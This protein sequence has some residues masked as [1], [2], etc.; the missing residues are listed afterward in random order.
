MSAAQPE[1]R[2]TPTARSSAPTPPED[3]RLAQHMAVFRRGTVDLIDEPSLRLRVAESLAEGRPLR[4]KFGMDPT[5]PDLH[6]GHAVHLL[7]LRDLQQL[8]HQIVLIVG[9]ATAMVGD[10]SGRN[11]L[12]PQLSRADVEEHLSTYLEQAGRVLELDRT[13]VRR[14]SEWFDAMR[15]EDVLRLAAK[16]TVAQMIERDTF[17]ARIQQAEPIG[18]HELLYPLMQGWDSVVVRSDVELGGTDQL[19]NLLVGRALQEREDQRP[20][21][22][23]TLPLLLGLDGRKMS[24]SYANYV[25][26]TDEPAD[27]FGKVMSIEDGAMGAWFRLLTRMPE[28]E[29]AQTLAGHPRDA[30]ARLAGELT[31]FFHGAEPAR[32]AGLAFDRLFRDGQVPEDVPELAWPAEGALPLAS[33]LHAVGLAASTSEARRVIQQGGVRLDGALELDPL[34]QIPPPGAG[35][36]VQV[37][38]RRFLRLRS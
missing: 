26:F 18:L 15:F 30:K 22:V 13:E 25:G 38:K 24:K 6:V 35:L 3:A 23:V 2:S 33:L 37:G 28:A 34:R 1:P 12:R 9:D 5:S 36:L 20:Q 19:F 8:G 17:Q 4:I 10:P 29:I 14:N 31:R 21:V 7:M 27:M 11:K 32:A 16:M